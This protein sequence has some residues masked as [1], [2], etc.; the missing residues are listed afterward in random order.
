MHIM[1]PKV[2]YSDIDYDYITLHYIAC[3]YMFLCAFHEFEIEHVLVLTAAT[4]SLAATVISS[5]DICE[6]HLLAS[7]CSNNVVQDAKPQKSKMATN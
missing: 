7:S 1:K 3:M 5:K 2:V 6:F 4:T